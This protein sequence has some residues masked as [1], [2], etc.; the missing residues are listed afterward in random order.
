[1]TDAN[2]VLG[3]LVPKHFMCGDIR[4]DPQRSWDFIH[5]LGAQSDFNT[6]ECAHGI[7]A[8]ANVHMERALRVISIEKSY[9]PRDFT[10]FSFGG[11]GGLHAVD[12]ARSLR[13]RNV[14]VS[15]YA[16]VLSA[17]GMLTADIIKYYVQTVMLSN[18]TAQDQID[19]CFSHL[20]TQGFSDIASQG[21]DH[22]NIII[23]RYLDARYQ[24]QS[25]E[26]TIP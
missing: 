8:V 19:D 21:V 20:V 3:R 16:S 25:Y 11:A 18:K 24:G 2:I 15:P 4:L 22:Q 14:L 26:L 1:M 12:L 13:I 17:F 23:E 5:K 10:L 6:V 9:D 7:L